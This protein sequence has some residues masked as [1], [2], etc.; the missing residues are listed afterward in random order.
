MLMGRQQVAYIAPD[1]IIDLLIIQ[2]GRCSI[3]LVK[4]DNSSLLNLRDAVD[5]LKSDYETINTILNKTLQSAGSI[6]LT[7]HNT[8]NRAQQQQQLRNTLSLIKK[9][10]HKLT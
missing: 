5:I 9:K 1:C 2:M 7:L 10:G 3:Y 4:N 8:A 6:N